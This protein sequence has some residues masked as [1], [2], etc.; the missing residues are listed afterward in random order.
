MTYQRLAP[1]V[2]I[3]LFVTWFVA[4][5]T[6]RDS[7]RRCFWCLLLVF[8]HRQ[9]TWTYVHVCAWTHVSLPYGVMR[10]YFCVAGVSIFICRVWPLRNVNHTHAHVHV[11]SAKII[12]EFDTA[13]LIFGC[14][15]LSPGQ[16]S[17][18]VFNIIMDFLD[19]L[20]CAA[21]SVSHPLQAH[22]GETAYCPRSYWCLRRLPPLLGLRPTGGGTKRNK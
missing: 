2:S 15:S 17:V 1:T 7:G 14:G 22:R 5:P 10:R 4:M 19:F 6:C 21:R 3:Q 18:I 16:P 13:A 8:A 11:D 12:A 20:I 9:C